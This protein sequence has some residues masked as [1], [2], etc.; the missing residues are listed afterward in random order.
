M[1][2]ADK[3]YEDAVQAP[4]MPGAAVKLG[5]PSLP[6]ESHLIFVGMKKEVW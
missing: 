2:H 5:S 4:D 6:P 1:S 3:A